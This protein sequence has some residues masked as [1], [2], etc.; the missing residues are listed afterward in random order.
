MW[1][2]GE[3]REQVTYLEMIIIYMFESLSHG[4]QKT[5]GIGAYSEG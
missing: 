1:Q 5:I 3:G 2:G 4:Y